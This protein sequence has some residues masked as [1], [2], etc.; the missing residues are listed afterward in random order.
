MTEGWSNYHPTHIQSTGG[1]G[2]ELHYLTSPGELLGAAQSC[3]LAEGERMAPVKSSLPLTRLRLG[4]VIRANC[5]SE[6]VMTPGS[7]H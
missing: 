2:S 3:S 5:S 4:P 6:V 7:T 1:A